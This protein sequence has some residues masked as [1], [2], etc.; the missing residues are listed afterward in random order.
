MSLG[1]LLGFIPQVTGRLVDDGKL[2]DIETKHGLERLDGETKERTNWYDALPVEYHSIP[3]TEF[4]KRVVD[5]GTPEFSDP[6][7]FKGHD[8]RIGVRDFQNYKYLNDIW[9]LVKKKAPPNTPI[10]ELLSL[11]SNQLSN[12]IKYKDENGWLWDQY[13]TPENMEAFNKYRDDSLKN[14]RD[15]LSSEHFN[16]FY[17]LF[18]GQNPLNVNELSKEHKIILN[19]LHHT[20]QRVTKLVNSLISEGYRQ[21]S[22]FLVNEIGGID[23]GG[24]RVSTYTFVLDNKLAPIENRN[25]SYLKKV[26]RLKI[27][28][29]STYM[30]DEV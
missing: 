20:P 16:S 23:D 18:F 4:L 1:A 28:N 10:P 9:D 30:R 19:N 6:N 15:G 5:Y 14:G 27:G 25:V 7:N 21:Q 17:D 8:G 13:N 3:A 12:T 26:G 29:T 2:S 22:P 11:F 24:H